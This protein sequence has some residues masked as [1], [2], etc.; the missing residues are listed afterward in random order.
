MTGRYPLSVGWQ[1]G[2]VK[3]SYDGGLSLNETTI[4]EVLKA[5]GYVNYIF[6]KWNLG[7]ESPRYLPTARGFD[8]F[9]GY[10]SSY[11][12]YWS[13]SDPE[14]PDFIDLMYADKD[15]YY[16]YD[17]K[18]MTDYST[19]LYRDK[20]VNRIESHDFSKPIFLYLPFQAVHDPFADAT[21]GFPGGLTKDNIAADTYDYIVKSYEVRSASNGRS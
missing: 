18:D 20:A 7:H 13:K 15:C 6:G 19:T 10:L 9:F 11:S 5:N 1:Y 12:T 17:S 8:Y 4:A 16:Q 2:D 3:D 21:A 14:H